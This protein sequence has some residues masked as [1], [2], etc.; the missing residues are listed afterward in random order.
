MS[1]EIRPSQIEATKDLTIA[2]LNAY[3]PKET[4]IDDRRRLAMNLFEAIYGVV[5][6]ITD[7]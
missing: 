3:P 6:K 1:K 4:T 7:E 2:V 5:R